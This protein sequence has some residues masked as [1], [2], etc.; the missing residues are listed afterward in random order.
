MLTQ[1]GA[2]ITIKASETPMKNLVEYRTILFVETEKMKQQNEFKISIKAFTLAGPN[3]LNNIDTKREANDSPKYTKDPIKACSLKS[4][5]I[6]FTISSND[7]GITPV[8]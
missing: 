4:N 6:S 3:L 2:Y 5:G 7:A 1:T 8:S